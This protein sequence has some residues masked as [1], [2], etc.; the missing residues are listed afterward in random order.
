M[1]II[2]I[3]SDIMCVRRKAAIYADYII[4][5]WQLWQKTTSVFQSAIM[6]VPF[7]ADI[8][9]FNTYNSEIIVS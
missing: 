1:R 2:M 3:Y 8:N 4:T 7:L 9:V 6:C 5:L